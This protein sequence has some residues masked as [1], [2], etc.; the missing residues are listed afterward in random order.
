MQ[1][2]TD[3]EGWPFQDY[4]EKGTE[5]NHVGGKKLGRS[6]KLLLHALEKTGKNNRGV[7]KGLN[8]A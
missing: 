8:S 4:W 7:K 6:A 1:R 5:G 2:A 3:A